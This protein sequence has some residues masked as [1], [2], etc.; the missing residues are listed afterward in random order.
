MSDLRSGASSPVRGGG[1]TTR[2]A[3]SFAPNHPTIPA[4][5]V[6]IL[7]GT[8][9][10]IALLP[11]EVSENYGAEIEPTPIM[12]RSSPIMGY[13][14]GGPKTVSLSLILYDDYCKDGIIQTVNNLK[15]LSYPEYSN[16]VEPPNCYVRIGDFIKLYGVCTSVGVSWSKPIRKD[17]VSGE[18]TYI[19]ADV[20]LEFQN[21]V[22]TPFSATSVERG[23]DSNVR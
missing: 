20:S 14:G 1:G 6:N 12:G 21:C 18:M 15:A 9:V 2:G 22:S 13:S 8:V 17:H 11:D 16:I 23:R 7:T 4:Y 3:L 5:I 19:K 10:E